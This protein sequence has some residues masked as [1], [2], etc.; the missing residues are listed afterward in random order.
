MS[1]REKGVT[2]AIGPSEIVL[3]TMATCVRGTVFEPVRIQKILF[4]ID[5]EI[6]ELVNGPHFRFR[7]YQYGPFDRAVFDELEVLRRAGSVAV[8]TE[9]RP[10]TYSLTDAGLAGGYELLRR[11]PEEV[12]SY[13]RDLTRW[14]L[15]LR[16]GRLLA[17]IYQRY[18]EMAA[19]SVAR[20]TADRF[21]SASRGVP[22]RP[23]LD[24]AMSVFDLSGLFGTSRPSGAASERRI[25]SG[26]EAIE[27]AWRSVGDDLRT[28]MADF[29]TDYSGKP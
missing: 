16:F 22:A 12:R 4:L 28:A 25:M 27:D 26:A 13:L 11:T 5:R 18:P 20:D 21:P 19:K 1:T 14:V 23:F 10:R 24:G 2:A 9:S 6:P 29:A 8:G 17:A 15:S 7:P 3:M